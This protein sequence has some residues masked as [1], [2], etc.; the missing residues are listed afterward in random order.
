M[1]S[2]PSRPSD[3]YTP[4]YFLVS[5]GSGGL[6][7]TFFMWLMHWLPHPGRSGPVF[8]DIA[9]KFSAG[10]LVTQAMIVVALA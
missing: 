3:A 1:E 8:E 4:L 5:L 10:S 6:V 7:V 2:A 9:A